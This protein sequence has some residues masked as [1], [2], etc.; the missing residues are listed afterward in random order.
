M[1][2][3]VTLL[4]LTTSLVALS[5]DAMLPALQQIGDELGATGANDNQLVVTALF[6][7]FAFGQ[8]IYGP[9]SDSVG[10]KPAIYAGFLVFIAGCIFCIA[11]E[12]FSTMLV[13]R[14]LQGIGAAGPRI[15]S[16]AIVRDRYAG[17]AM[18]RIM[19]MVM[20]VFIL[21]P[22][23]APALGQGIMFLAHWRAIF[24]ALLVL[25][26]TVSVW[27]ALRLPETLTSERRSP[28]SLWRMA[29]G[30]TETFRNRIAFGYTI[31]AGLSFS[32]FVAYLSSSQAI[33]QI[34]YG[35]GTHFPFYF[36]GLALC[37]GTASVVNAKLVMRFGMSWLAKRA[38]WTLSFASTAFFV[39]AFTAVEPQGHPPLGAFMAYCAVTFFCMGILFGN[40]NAM[41]ME[42]LGHIAGVA[43]AVVS[44]MATGIALFFSYL[45][46]QAYDGTVLPLVGGFAL[47]GFIAITVVAWT[48]RGLAPK[49]AKP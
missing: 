43:S 10:R 47:L 8:F 25:A 19:S 9:V 20:A 34:Q 7:G 5:I 36:G 6:L 31:A 3:F 16:M 26:M 41:A 37:I 2:E 18:A 28:L 40:F 13:G 1:P 24:W 42:P 15:V 33:L 30:V 29:R 11:A 21:V 45:I 12:S 39:F 32:A 46:S 14:V 22:V 35:L 4:A 48:E 27:F 17:A 23:L 38:L 49:R 44:A